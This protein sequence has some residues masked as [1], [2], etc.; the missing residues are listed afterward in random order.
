MPKKKSANKGK[1]KQN[2]S[3]RKTAVPRQPARMN[4]D[5]MAM[6]VCSLTDPFCQAAKAAKYPDANLAPTLSLQRKYPLSVTTDASGNGTVMVLPGYLY[7]YAAGTVTLVTGAYTSLTATSNMTAAR[8]RITS[9]GMVVSNVATPMSASGMVYFRTFAVSDASAL[10]S[11]AIT[12]YSC[13]WAQDIPLQDLKGVCIIP[14]PSNP[15]Y[16]DFITPSLTNASNTVSG[17]TPN[18]W[19]ITTISI[20]GGPVSATPIV[21]TLVV[22]YEVEFDEGDTMNQATASSPAM[23]NALMQAASQVKK[24]IPRLIKGGFEVAEKTVFALAKRYIATKLGALAGSFLGGPTGAMA[25][26]SVAAIMVD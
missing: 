24:S 11:V 3:A 5:H 4:T 14:K 15:D 17:Y 10:A 1:K 16:T 25:G 23:D 26:G 21:G 19:E 6:R 9:L 8:Y 22:N 13:T 12:T 2:T 7:N 18:G 20:I